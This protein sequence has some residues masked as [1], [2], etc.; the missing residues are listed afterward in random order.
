MGTP[1]RI[2]DLLEKRH[3]LVN[4]VRV[5]C[6]DEADLMLSTGFKEQME[7]VFRFLPHDTQVT[8]FSATIPGEMLKITEEFMRDPVRILV[9]RDELTLEGLK[10]FYVNV[11]D[12]KNKLDTLC[13]LYESLSI[14][15]AVFFVNTVSKAEWLAQRMRE[16]SFPV[17]SIHSGLS[18]EERETVLR[19]FRSGSARVLIATD[20]LARGIDVQSVNMVINYDLPANRENYIH[21]IGRSARFGRKGAAINFVCR[22]ELA[23][24]RDIEMFYNTHTHELPEDLKSILD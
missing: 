12:E 17:T 13:D 22:R 5:V 15:Q 18:W 10:Q 1:G 20:M 3:L 7:D 4:D 16:R 8:L 23:Y 6:I 19:A 2:Y 21:R 14:A 9:K 24:L 11:G